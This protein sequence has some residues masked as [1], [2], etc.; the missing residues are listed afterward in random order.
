MNKPSTFQTPN[1]ERF[2]GIIQNV[3]KSGKLQVVIE[4]EVIKEFGLKEVK[5]LY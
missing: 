4:D 1:Q 2:T 5:L 3:T